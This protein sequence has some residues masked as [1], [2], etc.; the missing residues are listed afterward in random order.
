M[1]KNYL[2]TALQYIKRHKGFSFINMSGLALA[3]ACSILVFI[4]VAHELSFDQ[5]YKNKSTLCVAFFDNGS[6]TTPPALAKFLKTQYPEIVDASRFSNAGRI[7]VQYNEK[8]FME[9]GGVLVD[10][11]FIDMFTLDFILGNSDKVFTHP[12]TVLISESFAKKYFGSDNPLGKTLVADGMDFKVEGVINDFPQ[13]SHIEFDFIL[14]FE[15]LSQMGRDLNTWNSNWHRTYIQLKQHV[16]L[17]DLNDKVIN[18]VRNHREQ[19]QRAFL[20]R[21]ITEI[22]LNRL[23]GGG[24][25]IFVYTFSIIGFLILFIACINFVNLSTAQASARAREVGMRKTLGVNRIDLIKQFYSESLIFIFIAWLIGLLIVTQVLP[26]FNS[27]TGKNFSIS[28]F[29]TIPVLSGIIGI[30]F[31]SGILAGSYPAYVLSSYKPILV[32]KGFHK[33]GNKGSQFR[34]VMV[35][36]QFSLSII[37]IFGSLVLYNQ[38]DY[39]ETMPLGFNKDNIITMRI[40]GKINNLDTFKNGLIN[41]PNIEKVTTTNVPPFRWN[42]NAGQGDVHWEGQQNSQ[43]RVVETTVDYDYA[44]TFGMEIVEGRFLQRDRVSDVTDAWVVNQAAVE[45]MGMDEQSGNG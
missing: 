31:V 18:V 25:I 30:L 7:K 22:Y 12:F 11:A 27:F 42:T 17:S 4:W 2:K 43:I 14:P 9:S 21:P 34:R 38:L 35:V 24:R 1:Y 32:L 20:L 15:L 3:I 29:M 5:F 37:M 6:W 40:D 36:F 33:T 45:A 39:I 16:S 13:N 28:D 26:E 10:P 23:G 8:V 44:E 41:H 19:D